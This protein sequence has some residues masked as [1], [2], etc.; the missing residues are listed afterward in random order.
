MNIEVQIKWKKLQKNAFTKI[1]SDK[2]ETTIQTLMFT[3]SIHG[4]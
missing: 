3:V 4:V 2:T 1:N